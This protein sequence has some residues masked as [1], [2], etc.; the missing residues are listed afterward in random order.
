MSSRTLFA[1]IVC[2]LIVIAVQPMTAA[3]ATPNLTG[4][5]Q[6]TLTPTTPPTPPVVVIP[7]LA[8]FTSDGSVVETDGSEFVAIPPSGT[9]A[10]RPSTPGHGIWQIG[11][12]PASLFVQ[13]FSIVFQADGALYAKNLTTMFLTLNSKGNQFSGTYTTTQV[14]GGVT[15]VLSSGTVSGTLIPHVPLP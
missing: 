8:T 9:P 1:L 6:F 3:A 15:T 12:T 2:G 7:G 14:M 11:N 5:W 10:A 13:Y 4:S